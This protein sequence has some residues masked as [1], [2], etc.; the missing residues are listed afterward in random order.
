MG[1]MNW[2]FLIDMKNIQISGEVNLEEL[3]SDLIRLLK[4]F[5]KSVSLRHGYPLFCAPLAAHFHF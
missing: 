4:I 1:E 2:T 3:N 5:N